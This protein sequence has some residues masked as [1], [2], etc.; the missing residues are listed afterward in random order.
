MH[1]TE[2]SLITLLAVMSLLPF[3]LAS[4]TCLIKFSIVLVL[5]RNA[6]G[7]QQVP[8]NLVLNSI[9]L[10][11]SAFV[12]QPVVTNTFQLVQETQTATSIDAV[13]P[14]FDT[15]LT[16]YRAYLTRYADKNLVH[17]FED[18]PRVHAQGDAV[19][20]AARAPSARQLVAPSLYALLSAY[21]LT[22]LREAFRIG[23]YLY[24]PFIVIDLIVSNVL[25]ALGMMMMS[26][27]TI[28]MPIKL[29]LF[30]ALD[31]WT[32]VAKDLVLPYMDGAQAG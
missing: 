17:F 21:A 2:L 10:M 5:L 3:V 27:V 22:E 6:I 14:Y 30:V 25:L 19:Q 4:G 15:V 29:I 23:F 28:A 11:L 12:M 32:L 18:L 7:V 8:S 26:P 16:P 1:N 9:A 24:L 31:G 13:Q 20:Y